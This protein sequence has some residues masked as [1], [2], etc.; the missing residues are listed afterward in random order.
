MDLA[1]LACCLGVGLGQGAA[2]AH[3]GSAQASGVATAGSLGW[4]WGVVGLCALVSACFGVAMGE[5]ESSESSARGRWRVGVSWVSLV[6]L[7][8]QALGVLAVWVQR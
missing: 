4:A 5:R 8:F 3:V 2:L 7:T 1:G 6:G